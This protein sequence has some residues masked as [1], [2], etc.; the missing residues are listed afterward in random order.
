[1]HKDGVTVT[2]I[3]PGYVRTSL[4]L[5]AL[6]GDGSTYGVMDETTARGMLPETVAQ[7]TLQA[8]ASGQ[9]D[10]VLADAKVLAAIQAAATLPELLAAVMRQK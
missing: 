8:I 7:Q 6:N 4:S 2:T 1:M 5:N 10:L 9:G 3:S